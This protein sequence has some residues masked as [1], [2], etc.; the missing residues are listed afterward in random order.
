MCLLVK[1]WRK[2]SIHSL[3]VGMQISVAT[4]V[5]RCLKMLKIEL[6]NDPA[7]LMGI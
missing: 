2:E 3:L 1:M 5:W 4:R 6:P 7:I